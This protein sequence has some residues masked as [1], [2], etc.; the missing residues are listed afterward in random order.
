MGHGPPAED[1]RSTIVDMPLCPADAELV[2]SHYGDIIE[3]YIPSAQTS[4][5]NFLVWS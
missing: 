4:K 2:S 1:L 5:T 3:R